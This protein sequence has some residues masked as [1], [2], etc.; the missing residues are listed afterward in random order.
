MAHVNGRNIALLKYEGKVFA[1][2]EKCPHMGKDIYHN[3]PKASDT[4]AICFSCWR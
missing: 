4:R 1:M 3:H 2:D